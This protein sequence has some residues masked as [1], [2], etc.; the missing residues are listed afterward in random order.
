MTSK[1]SNDWKWP[2]RGV[3]LEEI[4]EKLREAIGLNIDYRKDLVLGFP[5]TT[6]QAIA[7]TVNNEFVWWQANNIGCHTR[8]TEA[9]NGFSGSQNIERDF[10]GSLAGLFGASDPAG[11]VNPDNRI[12]GYFCSGGTDSNFNA[13]WIARNKLLGRQHGKVAVLCSFLTHYSIRKNCDELWIGE[14]RYEICTKCGAAHVFHP[15]EDGSG[16]HILPTN[17]DGEL[18]P[19]YL[20]RYIRGLLIQGIRHFIIVLNAG[21]INMGSI[22]P[23]PEVCTLVESLEAEMA[24]HV[25]FYVHVDAAFGGY[26]IPF[27]S[28]NY[29]FGFHN[30]RVDS[31]SVDA[32][33]MGLV[34]YPAGVFLCRKDYPQFVER[35]VG[36]VAGHV[37][38]TSCGSRPGLSPMCAWAV[39]KSLGREGYMEELSRGMQLLHCLR[40]GLWTIPGAVELFYESRMNILTVRF[41]EMTLKALE[42]PCADGES[43]AKKYCVVVDEFPS[44]LTDVNSCPVRICRFIAMP[45]YQQESIG[46]FLKELVEAMPKA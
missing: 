5:G 24:P 21:T 18:P 4:M 25:S 41:S 40:T 38:D 33:K 1:E 42:S 13:L 15:A 45:H 26:A 31:I 34:P 7:V 12:D 17:I 11:K 28:P 20:E 35:W 9:E 37:D 32:H 36:Y 14:G 16:L 6:P 3:P 30:P 43:L 19:I 27:L 8:R 39:M 10:I 2:E 22:D 29:P 23:I 46:Q 44:D